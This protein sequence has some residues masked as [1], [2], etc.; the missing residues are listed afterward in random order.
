L[1]GSLTLFHV[2]PRTDASL[3]SSPVTM[4]PNGVLSAIIRGFCR[5]AQYRATSSA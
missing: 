2:L 4:P 3:S 5:S 1:G